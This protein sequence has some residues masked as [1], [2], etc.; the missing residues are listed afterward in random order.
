MRFLPPLREFPFHSFHPT[1]FLSEKVNEKNAWFCHPSLS[2]PTPIN[3]TV[4]HLGLSVHNRDPLAAPGPSQFF[5]HIHLLFWCP[6]RHTW[7]QA[8]VPLALN[9]WAV[10]STSLSVSESPRI[11]PGN[12]V[13]P[14]TGAVAL[15]TFGKRPGFSAAWPL[16]LALC[17]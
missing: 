10:P 8:F 11:P 7:V 5:V 1:R 3:S 6:N 12:L 2:C 17:C 15:S 16:L 9:P 14:V 4:G 13:V